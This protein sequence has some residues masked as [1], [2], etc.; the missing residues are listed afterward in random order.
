MLLYNRIALDYLL[1]SGGS[2]CTII[3]IIYCIYINNSAKVGT[4]VTEFLT[5]P[6]G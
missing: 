6:L 5:M 4:H 1:A 3:N 2:V